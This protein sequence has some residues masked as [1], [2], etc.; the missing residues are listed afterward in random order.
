MNTKTEY[1][2]IVVVSELFLFFYVD[3]KL[4]LP[5]LTDED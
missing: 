5:I 3:Y 2:V 4:F 1:R